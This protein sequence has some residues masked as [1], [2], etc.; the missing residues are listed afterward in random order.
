MRE[1][2]KGCGF[3]G[4]GHGKESR[5]IWERAN[6]NQNILYLKFLFLIKNKMC[7]HVCVFLLLVSLSNDCLLVV[8]NIFKYSS[9]LLVKH[10]C[11]VTMM[12]FK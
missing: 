8:E 5:R 3:G 1:R 10:R 7:A 2:N 6:H 4:W 9:Q 12:N 11:N